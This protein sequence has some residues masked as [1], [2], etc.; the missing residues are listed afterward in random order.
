MAQLGRA[1]TILIRAAEV[2]H[3]MHDDVD[4]WGA[5]SECHALVSKGEGERARLAMRRACHAAGVSNRRLLR[6][7]MRRAMG[8]DRFV[9][10]RFGFVPY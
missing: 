3:A 4:A 8:N 7:A 6:K 9:Y 5:P 1:L 2:E 10:H